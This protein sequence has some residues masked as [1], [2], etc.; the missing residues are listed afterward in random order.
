[1][2]EVYFQ[3]LAAQEFRSARKWYAARSPRAADRFR[4]SVSAAVERIASTGDS[5]PV[6]EG[7]YRYVQ[8]KR[9]P[10]LLI[11]RRR[12]GGD[13]LVVAV[14]HTSRRPGYWRGRH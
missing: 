5:L 8:V 7:D 11:F 12:I 14:A 4:L 6:L 3:R 2:T 13:F 1:M 9:F 10:Y